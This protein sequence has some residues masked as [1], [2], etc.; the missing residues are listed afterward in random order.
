MPD[1]ARRHHQLIGGR[2]KCGVKAV[3]P[4]LSHLR[5]T[6]EVEIG[7][8]T[9]ETVHA[10]SELTAILRKTQPEARSAMLGTL[11]LAPNPWSSSRRRSGRN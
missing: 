11:H 7:L 8:I 2:A 1:W 9:N 10:R 4:I 6:D 5:A 3:L